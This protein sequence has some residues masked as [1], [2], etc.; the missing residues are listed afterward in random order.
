MAS[1]IYPTN[2][3]ITEVAQTLLPTLTA[4]DPIFDFFPI[5]ERNAPLLVWDQE[6]NYVGLQGLRGVD[7]APQRVKRA[8]VSRFTQQP[9]VFGEYTEIDEME[10]MFRAPSGTFGGAVDV[11][12]LIMRC[13]K[14][15]VNREYNRIREMLWT[16]AATGTFSIPLAATQNGDTSK[17]AYTDSYSVQT[18][19]GSNWGAPTTATPLADFRSAR[20]KAR[21]YSVRFD[22]SAKAFMNMK[23][24]QKL[25]TVTNA[26]DI[27][28]KRTAGLATVIGERDVNYVLTGEDLPQIVINDD[29]YLR[30]SDNAFVPFIADDKVVIMGRRTDNEPIGE[31][32]KTLNVNAEDGNGNAIVTTGSYLRVIEPLQIPRTPQVHAG[33]NGGPLIR[34]PSAIVVL[35]VGA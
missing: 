3:E 21:G 10:L 20:L 26:A 18:V 30:E 2:A 17:V 6:D 34:F 32:R 15:L 33:H 25:F 13:T 8:G 1:Y 9:G 5:T 22:A 14:Q 35:S 12:D 11:E 24:A 27:G 23:T 4:N 19:T 7:G 31:Y 29:G 16:L 28:G